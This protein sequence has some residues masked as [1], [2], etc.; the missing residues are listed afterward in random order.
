MSESDLSPASKWLII[1]FIGIFI[2]GAWA[3]LFGISLVLNNALTEAASSNTKAA[4]SAVKEEAKAEALKIVK[5]ELSKF[6]RIEKRLE[7]SAEKAYK[8]EVRAYTSAENASQTLKKFEELTVQLPAAQKAVEAIKDLSVGRNDII[9]NLV[10]S[11]EFK[12]DVASGVSPL[13]VGM[14]ISSVLEP[15]MFRESVSDIGP[16]YKW[17]LAD[18]RQIKESTK[19]FELT[20]NNKIPDLRGVF[21]RG[22]NSGRDDKFQDPDGERS[23]GHIQP[24]AI[25]DHHHT[26]NIPNAHE[27]KGDGRGYAR[28]NVNSYADEPHYKPTIMTSNIAS[29]DKENLSKENRPK[30]AAVFF[31]IKID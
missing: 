9:S 6:N 3:I 25:V 7:D 20:R 18:G 26:V 31:Y 11:D 2:A 19:Y 30:N 16:D 5:D 12:S 21:L 8:A 13:P 17:V 23:P 1:K 14:V 28:I 4:I 15:S 24:D 22:I 10:N 29:I 27:D